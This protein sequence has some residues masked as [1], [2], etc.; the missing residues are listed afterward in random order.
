MT[1]PTSMT[2]DLKSDTLY[3]TEFRK[4]IVAI[5]VTP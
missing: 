5:S 2:L 4:R 3:V 1:C